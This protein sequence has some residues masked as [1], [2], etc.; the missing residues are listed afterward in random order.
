[1]NYRLKPISYPIHQ[2]MDNWLFFKLN[3]LLKRGLLFL[4]FPIL[5]LTS[6]L[7]NEDDDELLGNWL[8]GSDFEGVTR[9]GAISFTIGNFAYVGLGYDGDDYLKD[10]WRFDPTLNFWERVDTFPGIGRTGAVAFSIA[11][12]GYIGTGYNGDLDIEFEDFW[13]FDPS[14]STGQMWQQKTD[15]MGSPRYNAVGFAIGEA[16]YIGTGYDGNYLKDFYKY[17]PS[18]DSWEQIVSL[19][20]S[21]RE[22]AVAFV[23][24]NKAYVGTG[25][26]N[27]AYQFDFWEYDPNLKNWTAKLDIDEEDDYTVFRHGA[28]AFSLDGLG[29]IATGST[30]VNLGTVWQYDPD[31]DTWEEMTA[32][33]GSARVD[34]VGFTVANR[35]YVT[36]GRS[37]SFRF[38]DLWEFR[39]LEE[40][41]EDD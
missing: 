5:L 11:G 4:I 27:G 1:M 14:A 30:G 39:P 9:S 41:D 25:R 22:D 23:I 16:G 2:I 12:K 40:Y 31:A 18:T 35:I 17:A 21:K 20:G 32:L 10:F 3:T 13:E 6:C 29:Y 37:G 7:N 34:A 24:N 26:S 19:G 28:V 8:K 38:D 15:F 33:E 36:T